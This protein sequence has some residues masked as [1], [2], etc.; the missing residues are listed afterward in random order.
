MRIFVVLLI[1]FPPLAFAGQRESDMFG[2]IGFSRDY[3]TAKSESGS[4]SSFSGWGLNAEAGVEL[5]WS[6]GSGVLF[7]GTYDQIDYANNGNDSTLA[8]SGKGTGYGAKLGLYFGPITV[9]GGYRML[10]LSTRTV[11][12]GAPSESTDIEGN[13]SFAFINM[14][15]NLGD[16]RKRAV[17]EVNAGQGSLD[18]L[19]S[20]SVQILLKIGISEFFD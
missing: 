16:K 9:G 14:M 5:A 3:L 11:I 4:E 2:V 1:F 18:D 7:S 8:E 20:T 10:K 12:T 13:E 15:F 17:V 6:N 19:K